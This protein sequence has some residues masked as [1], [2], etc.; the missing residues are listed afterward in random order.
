MLCYEDLM[1]LVRANFFEELTITLRFGEGQDCNRQ[2]RRETTKAQDKVTH[3]R[4]GQNQSLVKGEPG[5]RL[6][7]PGTMPEEV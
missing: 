3:L 5:W 2:R 1:H 6:Q 4:Y 7:N